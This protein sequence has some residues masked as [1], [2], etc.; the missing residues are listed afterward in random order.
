M[1]EKFE[2]GSYVSLRFASR[3][4]SSAFFGYYDKS[5][6]DA[7]GKRLLAHQVPFDGR[8][9]R[10]DDVADVGYFD[11]DGGTWH[12][13]GQTHAF[14]WQQGSMLQWLGPDFS[15]QI[16]YNDRREDRFV[17]VIVDISTGDRKVIPYPIYAVHPSGEFALGVRFE[18]HYFCRAYHYEGVVKPEWDRPIHPDDGILLVDLDSGKGEL[19]VRT[20]EIARLDPVPQQDDV[21]NWLEHIFWNPS[22]SRFLFMHRFGAGEDFTTRLFSMDWNGKGLY[23]FPDCG[24][25]SHLA[26]RTDQEFI[27]WARSSSFRRRT[28]VMNAEK[29]PLWFSPIAW[30]YRFAKKHLLPVDVIRRIRGEAF[31]RCWDGT[32]K[33]KA[34]APG[35]LEEDG[36]PVWTRDVRFMLTDTYADRDGYRHLFLFE[37]EKNALHKLGKFFSPYNNC[38]YRCDLHPRFSRDEQYVIVDSAHNDRRQILLLKVNWAHI[39]CP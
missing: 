26:W 5:P 34:V 10:A 4:Q 11:L 14:N 36:H 13:V 2:L 27:V 21:N 16:I 1:S 28:Y 33:M 25:Y 30:G 31:F 35:L 23:L 7:R 18:R 20:E 9:I 37:Y 29:K 8:E 6:I 15:S 32:R 24:M 3:P 38:G 22:G 39:T 12:S 17:S 19:V